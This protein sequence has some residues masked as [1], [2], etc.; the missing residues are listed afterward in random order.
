M[1][2]SLNPDRNKRS[3]IIIIIIII[4]QFI[5]ALNVK[6]TALLDMTPCHL[7]GT[8]VS[9]EPAVSMLM[10]EEETCGLC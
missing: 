6:A 8:N 10:V 9:K 5:K 4:A 7:V 2:K 3:R 1:S